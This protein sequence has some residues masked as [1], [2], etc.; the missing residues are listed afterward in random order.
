M[1]VRLRSNMVESY[2]PYE[3]THPVTRLTAW[4]SRCATSQSCPLSLFSKILIQPRRPSDLT[5]ISYFTIYFEIRVDE[6]RPSK[7][8]ED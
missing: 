3:T 1:T 4:F 6:V 5:Y 2:A 8:S 7:L